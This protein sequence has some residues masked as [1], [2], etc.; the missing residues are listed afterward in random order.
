MDRSGGRKYFLRADAFDAWLEALVFSFHGCRMNI[1]LGA[2][3]F[4]PSTLW[5][6]PQA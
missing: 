5:Q 1:G 2:C 4:E 6:A 3:F